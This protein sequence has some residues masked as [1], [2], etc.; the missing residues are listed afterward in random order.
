MTWLVY[1]L[2][3]S[4]IYIIILVIVM[5]DDTFSLSFYFR[6][7][8]IFLLLLRCIIGVECLIYISS[9]SIGLYLG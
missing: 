1:L 2:V 5:S 8:L 4:W 9:Q 3:E 7:Y 6:L